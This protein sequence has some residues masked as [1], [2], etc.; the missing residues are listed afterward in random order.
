M[1]KG[2]DIVIE[3]KHCLPKKKERKNNENIKKIVIDVGSFIVNININN[4]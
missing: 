3:E 1:Y 4:Y 2:M